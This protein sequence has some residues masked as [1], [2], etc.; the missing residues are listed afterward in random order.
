MPPGIVANR[1]K[2]PHQQRELSGEGDALHEQQRQEEEE[3]RRRRP[4]P[5]LV[6]PRNTLEH[7]S[8]RKE[9]THD[10]AGGYVDGECSVFGAEDRRSAAAGGRW[11][12]ELGE[13]GGVEAGEEAK[14]DVLGSHCEI[15]AL[16]ETTLKNIYIFKMN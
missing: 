13:E 15:Y 7:V 1:H 14:C 12:G 11:E 6:A 2:R 4:E 9:E 10:G 5:L 16:V 8:G 3:V